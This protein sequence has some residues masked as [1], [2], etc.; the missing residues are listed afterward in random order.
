M[1]LKIL[2]VVLLA[3]SILGSCS[4]KD[5]NN[6]NNTDTNS[7][8]NVTATISGG[9]WKITY[10]LESGLDKTSDFAGYKFTFSNGGML[11]AIRA[12][13]NE[14]G[15]WSAGTDNSKTKLTINFSGSAIFSKLNEDWEVIERTHSSVKLQHV[16]G[17]GGGTDLLTFEKN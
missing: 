9:N 15:T 16:S 12:A 17:G 10:F 13:N 11:V 2:T 8:A 1:K 5:D 7:P 6:N 3:C 14:K 4:K